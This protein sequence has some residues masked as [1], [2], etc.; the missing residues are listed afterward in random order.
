M[1]GWINKNDLVIF[2]FNISSLCDTITVILGIV[3]VTTMWVATT[4]TNPL[5]IVA[6][7]EEIMGVRGTAGTTDGMIGSSVGMM[8]GSVEGVMNE[9]VEWGVIVVTVWDLT[10]EKHWGDKMLW[11]LAPKKT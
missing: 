2:I 5:L 6:M 7:I 8:I 11:F 3:T 1:I 9:G 10:D 4:E